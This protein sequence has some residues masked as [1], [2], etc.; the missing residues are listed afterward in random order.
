MPSIPRQHSSHTDNICDHLKNSITAVLS[1]WQDSAPNAVSKHIN[2]M[3]SCPG[4]YFPSIC[5][6]LT[7]GSSWYECVILRVTLSDHSKPVITI[8]GIQIYAC[9]FTQQLTS[10]SLSLLQSDPLSLLLIR[11]VNHL[12]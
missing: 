6:F 8:S 10:L 5:S 2:L 7:P 9:C 12:S 4:T 1:C 3:T 11:S